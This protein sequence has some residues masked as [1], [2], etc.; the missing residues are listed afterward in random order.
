MAAK[1]HLQWLALVGALAVTAACDRLD[2]LGQLTSDAL[3]QITGGDVETPAGPA[4]DTLQAAHLDKY[5]T[6]LRAKGGV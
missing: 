4:V 6:E 3:K 1:R 5:F 2:Q